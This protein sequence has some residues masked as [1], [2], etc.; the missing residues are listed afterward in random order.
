MRTCTA[1][2]LAVS[3]GCAGCGDSDGEPTDAAADGGGRDTV[4]ADTAVDGTGSCAVAGT[5]DATKLVCGTFDATDA[6][7]TQGLVETL[8]MTV[9]T[10]ATGGCLYRWTI[11]GPNCTEVE[12]GEQPPNTQVAELR[13]I[14]SCD[15]PGCAFNANDAACVIGDRAGAAPLVFSEPAAG[16]VEISTPGNSGLCGGATP[17]TV[18]LVRR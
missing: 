2:L 6:I 8:V 5:W 3:L 14:V 7:R 16:T 1:L 10:T 17:L 15:P 18:T 9:T 11:S 4:S 12:E 13:G